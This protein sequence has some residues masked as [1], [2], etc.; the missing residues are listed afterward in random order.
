[1]K[2]VSLKDLKTHNRQVILQALIDGQSSSRIGLAQSTGLAPSTISSLVSELIE[3][4]VLVESGLTLSTGG[5]GRKELNVNPDYGLIAVIEISRQRTSLHVYNMALEKMEEKPIALRRL[6]G[7]SL[8]YEISVAI[9]ECFYKKD[10]HLRLAGIGLLFQEDM[11]E[12]DLNVMYSTSLSSDNI[13]L[14]EALYTQFK[15]PVAGEYFVSEILAV[16]ELTQ[17]VRNSA[18]IAIANTVLI[19]ITIDGHPLKMR[20]GKNANI[21]RLLQALEGNMLGEEELA[22]PHLMRRFAGVLALLCSLF[23]LELILLSGRGVKNK[24]FV[25]TLADT[26]GRALAPDTPPPVKTVES[27]ESEMTGKMALQLRRIILCT[28]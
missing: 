26:L 13:S 28:D 22:Q 25:K 9:F 5:R 18:H 23:P 6:S 27:S 16:P 10:D 3:D 14:R 24:G 20:G 7:N 11:I 8:F 15:V 21:T 2:K 1:M 17:E 4:E 19:S 12:S